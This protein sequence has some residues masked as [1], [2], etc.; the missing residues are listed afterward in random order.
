MKSEYELNCE[1]LER[2]MDAMRKCRIEREQKHGWLD[3]KTI[4]LYYTYRIKPEP[5]RVPLELKDWAGGPWWVR[6]SPDYI[7]R[8]IIGVDDS[9][10]VG[11]QFRIMIGPTSEKNVRTDEIKGWQRT[12]DFVNIEPCS[13]E[14]SE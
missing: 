8:P 5:K 2:V 12:R 14:V 10:M 9:S 4:G 6:S 1:A 7:W 3:A 11:V 13:K